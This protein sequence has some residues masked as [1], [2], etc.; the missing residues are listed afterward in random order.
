MENFK[1]SVFFMV[2][3]RIYIL[4]YLFSVNSDKNNLTLNQHYCAISLL[5]T[6]KLV[7]W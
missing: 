4:I 6:N 3:Q 5:F 1:T 2:F 7:E